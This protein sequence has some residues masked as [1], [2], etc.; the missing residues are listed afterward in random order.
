L[1]VSTRLRLV[2]SFIEVSCCLLVVS[3][4]STRSRSARLLVVSCKSTRLRL[5]VSLKIE[6]SCKS[7]RLRLAVSLLAVS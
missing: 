5:V 6:V 7:T 1:A 4:K 3:C 2:V